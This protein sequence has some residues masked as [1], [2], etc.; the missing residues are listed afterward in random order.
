MFDFAALVGFLALAYAGMTRFIQNKLIDKNA[1]EAIQAES[2]RLS[3]EFEKAKKA[4]DK[5]RM[6]RAMQD[7]MDHLP[8]LNGVMMKQFRPMLVILIVFAAFTWILGQVD[9]YTKDDIYINLTDDGS[10]CDR[11]PGDGIFT[12]CMRLDSQNAGK[13]TISAK[14]Y[15]G[16]S[17]TEIAGNETYFLFDSTDTSDTYVEL[18]KGEGMQLETDR[19]AYENGDTVMITAKPAEM[20]K[21]ASFI[22]PIA[23][24]REIKADRVVAILSNGTYFRVDLPLT[25]PIFNVKTI[26]QPYW[27]FILVSLVGNLGVSFVIGQY[28][29]M[30]KAKE[31]KK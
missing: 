15:E 16:G 31:G 18:G 7:Q 23:P 8:K 21:G 10:G 4:N 9:P 5:K 20:T 17:N 22:V 24:P 1:V 11:V 2:K 13:W 12:G 25:I 28:T 19:K 26:Y 6:D 29:K 30:T 27:W 14:A 3:E